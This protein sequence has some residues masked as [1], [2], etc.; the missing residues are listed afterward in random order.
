MKIIKN[1]K[2]IF[3]G[4]AIAAAIIAIIPVSIAYIFSGLSVGIEEGDNQEIIEEKVNSYFEGDKFTEDIINSMRNEPSGDFNVYAVN[5]NSEKFKEV[6]DKM[7]VM[8]P[9]IVELNRLENGKNY[10]I[11]VYSDFYEGEKKIS[12]ERLL[13]KDIVKMGVMVPQIVELN[14]LENGKNY[15]IK[16][17]SDFYEG[18]KKISTERLLS[19]DIVGS[20]SF[21]IIYGDTFMEG[22]SRRDTTLYFVENKEIIETLKYYIPT[23]YNES[24]CVQDADFNINEDIPLMSFTRGIKVDGK[25]KTYSPEMHK[26]KDEIEKS[27]QKQVSKNEKMVILRLEVNEVV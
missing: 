4:V 24:G 5:P 17:Y 8:V 14:R 2:K 1:N 26:K 3:I 23:N 15:N 13:S 9:Q 19:K 18:E 10:N 20:D 6:E 7:G 22:G 21:H 12:T 16:V 27:I 25:Y 11:K